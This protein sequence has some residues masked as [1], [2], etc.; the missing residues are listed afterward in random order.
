MGTNEPGSP[1]GAA[2]GN[3]DDEDEDCNESDDEEAN[4][5]NLKNINDNLLPITKMASLS[6]M[7]FRRS[8]LDSS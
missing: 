6:H 4:E 3:E 8:K 1:G 7:I 2:T 5:G